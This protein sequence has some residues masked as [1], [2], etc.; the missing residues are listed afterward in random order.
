M[1]FLASIIASVFAAVLCD[2][3]G[4]V[5]GGPG[6]VRYETL[7]SRVPADFRHARDGRTCARTFGAG[8]QRCG[9]PAEAPMCYH[10]AVGQQ[11]CSNGSKVTYCLLSLHCLRPLP[12]PLCTVPWQ[13]TE[14]AVADSP[15]LSTEFCRIGS[16]C[17]S[18]GG[19][20]REVSLPDVAQEPQ[21]PPHS[22]AHPAPNG[23]RRLPKA[24][25]LRHPRSHT[26]LSPCFYAVFLL[27]LARR[28]EGLPVLGC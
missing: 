23:P 14:N 26:S 12:S 28:L 15:S 13:T 17:T 1:R 25:L 4:A 5:A 19:C 10:P 16:Y 18:D 6:Y 2:G 27:F 21:H 9:G 3:V 24:A 7:P 20:C 22:I 11:C 8:W